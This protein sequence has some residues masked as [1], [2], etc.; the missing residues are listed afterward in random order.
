MNFKTV[1]KKKPIT[2]RCVYSSAVN[3]LDKGEKAT[4]IVN[5][6]EKTPDCSDVDSSE[7]NT[8]LHHIPQNLGEGIGTP[9]SFGEIPSP[10]GNVAVEVNGMH[11]NMCIKCPGVFIN[12]VN[13]LNFSRFCR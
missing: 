4:T 5:V 10:S 1:F 11:K 13:V 8:W 9:K 6:H 12:F 2:N 7:D 3:L